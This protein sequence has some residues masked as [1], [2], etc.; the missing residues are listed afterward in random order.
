MDLQGPWG[1]GRI[2]LN[3]S[4]FPSP[5]TDPCYIIS[6]S[7]GRLV[8]AAQCGAFVENNITR[9]YTRR[10]HFSKMSSHSSTNSTHKL[11]PVSSSTKN[12][13]SHMNSG[14]CYT[15]ALHL[16]LSSGRCCRCGLLEQRIEVSSRQVCHLTCLCRLYMCRGNR[17]RYSN[18]ILVSV[19]Y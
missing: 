11:Q 1:H 4:H 15:T 6:S 10:I 19:L 2:V 16:P 18:G 8:V 3:Q 12:P 7:S 13:H 17:P 5:E 14:C 9:Y